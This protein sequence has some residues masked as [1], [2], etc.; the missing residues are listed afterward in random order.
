MIQLLAMIL[1][2]LAY[3]PVQ[4]L[5]HLIARLRPS[6]WARVDV[7]QKCPACGHRQGKIVCREAEL[8]AGRTALIEH[9]C[10]VCGALA[11]EP[12]IVKPEQWLAGQR[13][14]T[15]PQ[16]QPPGSGK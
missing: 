16:S 2:G 3:W 10:Q 1:R 7:N 14:R 11:Y 12:T 15:P 4:W 9:Q 13:P 8:Q 5:R 6:W